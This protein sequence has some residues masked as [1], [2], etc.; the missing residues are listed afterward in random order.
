MAE[1]ADR[2]VFILGAGFSA[3]A[4]IPLIRNFLDRAR[5]LKDAPN[6]N[7]ELFE[8]EHFQ[9]VFDFRRQMAQSREKV[10]MDLDNIEELFGLV[11][12]ST[13]LGEFP[14]ETRA[15]TV[16]LIAK[17]LQLATRPR[18]ARRRII[19]TVNQNVLSKLAI[20]QY[21]DVFVYQENSSPPGFLV[22][23]Y[24]YFAAL[25][26]GFLDE[27][28]RQDS[29][30]NTVIT[31]NYDLV[32]DHALERLGTRVN[33]HLPDALLLS[34]GG[35]VPR[36]CSVLKL[37][38]STNWGV[39]TSCTEHVC[40]LPS[41]VTESPAEFLNRRCPKCNAQAYQPLLIPPSWDKSEY[42]EIM[43]P[44]WAA[45]VEELRRASRICIIGYSMPPSD[46]FFK[47]LLTVALSKNH[48]L[49][50]LLVVDYSDRSGEI[51]PPAGPE[52][53][54]LRSRYIAMLDRLFCERRFRFFDEGLER[55]IGTGQR[56][57]LQLG[58]GELILP[59]GVL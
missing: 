46:S 4:G 48:G 50:K 33:Y 28:S 13:R 30:I 18:G 56:A 15:S 37:H 20:Q 54:E 11:E 26:T 39:C 35:N 45:A 19:F 44:V 17:T 36:C 58:R 49:Y 3:A 32:F 23:V 51:D 12:I 41:K 29:R 31:F 59:N 24:D 25:V 38:G 22:D 2:N 16:Y 34:E 55:F 8:R 21:P 53:D 14:P 27:T 5:E 1:I 47:Y 7:L 9:N 52:T 42:R 40:V 10:I 57:L 6:S 43:K